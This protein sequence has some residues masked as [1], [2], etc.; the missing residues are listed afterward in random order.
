MHLVL[1][2]RAYG[3]EDARASL[4]G[5]R[6]SSMTATMER[7][8]GSLPGLELGSLPGLDL[9]WRAGSAGTKG[10]SLEGASHP[11]LLHKRL[12]ERNGQVRVG[13][14]SFF[15]VPTH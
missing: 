12:H 2:S 6:L 11:S 5:L 3:L 1:K 13:L 15:Q 14:H 9:A 7:T 10:P 8:L 4:S